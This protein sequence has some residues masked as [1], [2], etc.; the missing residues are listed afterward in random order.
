MQNFNKLINLKFQT[1]TGKAFEINTP[2]HGF[3]PQIEI[4]GN[5]TMEG[6][7]HTFEVRITN[8]FSDSI[9]GDITDI[10]V[11]AG[12]EGKMSAGIFGT[13]QNVYTE[14]PGPDKV[15]VLSCVSANY[16]AWINK[17]IDLKLT[18]GFTLG[19][20]VEQVTKALGY[21]PAIIDSAII[22][23]T[24]V[25]PL[26]HNGRCTEALQK[27]KNAF[28]GVSI[29]TDGKK[30]RVFP[31]EAKSQN[32]VI[33]SLPLLIQP[34]QFSGGMVNIVAPWESMVKPGDYVQFPTTFNKKTLGSIVSNLAMVSTIQFHFATNTDENEMIISG[35]IDSK[36]KADIAEASTKKA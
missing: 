33:H 34:P 1:S 14:S 6:Y 15:T 4:T 35:T 16:D 8:F 20:A 24:C 5:L 13:V 31:T 28:P 29:I 7:T 27:I 21:E 2:R 23:K 26:N 32:M 17:T 36:L 18:G 19:T 22:T 10:I 30:L 25:A 11:T 9:E 3:K 12:Y